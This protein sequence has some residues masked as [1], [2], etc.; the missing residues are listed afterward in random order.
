MQIIVRNN[1]VIVPISIQDK[2]IKT[3]VFH[4]KVQII[5][6]NDQM[7]CSLV[8]TC[9]VRKEKCK[10]S[11]DN[12]ICNKKQPASGLCKECA[13]KLREEKEIAAK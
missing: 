13:H 2:T 10:A 7:I 6:D 5:N 12:V 8:N 9:H 4:S 3:Y 1:L 11:L